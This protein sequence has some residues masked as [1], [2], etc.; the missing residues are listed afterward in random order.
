M[1]TRISVN[2]GGRAEGDEAEGNEENAHDDVV[3]DGNH[4]KDGMRWSN[5]GVL[6]RVDP[7]APAKITVLK[8]TQPLAKTLPGAEV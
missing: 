2:R 6:G 3:G 1:L 4:I 5:Q 8:I 7:R